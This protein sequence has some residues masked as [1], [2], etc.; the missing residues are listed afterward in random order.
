MEKIKNTKNILLLPLA[1]W[2]VYLILWVGINAF[3]WSFSKDDYTDSY[4][5]IALTTGIVGLIS[6][7]NWGLFKSRFGATI[8]YISI[9]LLL[10]FL[11]HAIYAYYFRVKD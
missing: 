3:D 4:S 7:R 11:G 6:A 10:Q 1:L 9:G 8:G 5:I 2:V